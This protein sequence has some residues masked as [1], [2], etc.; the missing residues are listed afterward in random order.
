MN[1]LATYIFVPLIVMIYY[2]KMLFTTWI[3]QNTSRVSYDKCP[4]VLPYT[5]KYTTEETHMYM[6]MTLCMCVSAIWL[7]DFPS[8]GLLGNFAS[9]MS[10]MAHSCWQQPGSRSDL[11]PRL[12]HHAKGS[13]PN[14]RWRLMGVTLSCW[15]RSKWPIR[16]SISSHITIH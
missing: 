10:V 13:T 12:C 9:R 6:F 8:T 4:H 5:P 14:V 15:P 11:P 2:P 16:L 7:N 1:M 3:Y